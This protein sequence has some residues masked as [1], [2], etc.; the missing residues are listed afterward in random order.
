MKTNNTEYGKTDLQLQEA[1]ELVRIGDLTEAKKILG[2][3]LKNYPEESQAWLLL[4]NVLEGQEDTISEMQKLLQE[5]PESQQAIAWLSS[6]SAPTLE[7]SSEQRGTAFSAKTDNIIFQGDSQ[8][9]I[10]ENLGFADP[11]MLDDAIENV[12]T[13]SLL[14]RLIKRRTILITG[15]LSSLTSAIANEFIIEGDKVVIVGDNVDKLA[16]GLE[17]ATLHSYNPSDSVFR[18]VLSSYKFDMVIFISTRED[19]LL[20]TGNINTGR[21][22]DELRNTLELSKSVIRFIYISSTEVYGKNEDMLKF[23]KPHPVTV[24]RNTLLAGEQYCNFYRQN[25]GLNTLILRVPFIYGP[26]EKSTLLQ[27]ILNDCIHQKNIELPAGEDTIINFLHAEDVADF[28]KR[29]LDEGHRSRTPVIDL[30]SADNL[31]FRELVELLEF[32]F[33]GINTKFN[34]THTIFTQ[35]VEISGARSEFDWIVQHKFSEEL[36]KM[37]ESIIDVDVP[38]IS[39]FENVKVALSQ[40]QTLGILKWVELTFGAALMQY[41]VEVTG[42]LLQFKV[43]DFRLL[44]VVIMG[45]MYGT[46]LGLLASIL[47]VTSGLFGWYRLNFDWSLLIYNVENWLPFVI[48][49]IAGSITGY[50]KDKNENEISF[51]I[52]EMDLI[53]EKYSFLYGVYSEISQLKEQFR[54]QLIGYRDSFGRI[55]KVTSELDK[56]QEDE[57]FYQALIILEDIMANDSIAIYAIDKNSQFARL[58]VSSRS[59]S[60]KIE[61][62]LNLSDFPEMMDLFKRGE[63]FQN[64]ELL[65]NYPVYFAPIMYENVPIAAIAI[66]E[67]NFE[68]YSLYYANLFKVMCGLI[69]SSL[70]RA[71]LFL[72]SNVD[73]VYIAGTNILESEPFSDILDIKKKM[74]KSQVSDYQL[75]KVEPNEKNII[76]LSLDISKGIRTTDFIGIINGDYFVL[77]S[78]S[79]AKNANIIIA[80]LNKLG[81]VSELVDR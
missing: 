32:D 64:S 33:P 21:T 69:Q 20:N 44:Y 6:L 31:T 46:T 48:Y 73:K 39:I 16:L 29:V 18:D 61:H 42:T 2:N 72:E 1:V 53:R 22:L 50:L 35:P 37:I 24:N 14:S 11:I 63:I 7:P 66:L 27:S 17:K 30:S 9:H 77:L 65:E 78:Q 47:A 4:I 26:D 25:Y 59:L 10:N 8:E 3:F 70:V 76:D 67:S 45:S 75:I 79:D 55:Y 51:N 40:Y 43:I 58:E 41:L 36:P 60:D 15:D 68:Q 62:S 38:K 19:Q 52:E 28:I 49:F 56:L 74:R 71:S 34:E 12:G 5:D 57:V 23:V 80:R 54:E 13:S 81:I